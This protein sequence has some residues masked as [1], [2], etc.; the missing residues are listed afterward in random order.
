M[1]AVQGQF[2]KDQ[3]LLDLVATIKDVYSFAE[4]ARSISAS[5]LHRENIIVKIL[6]QTVECSIFI[7]EYTG[8]G[9]AGEH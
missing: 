4:T 1:Q 9:F 8:L 3:Q 6:Q 7:R 2:L 5:L